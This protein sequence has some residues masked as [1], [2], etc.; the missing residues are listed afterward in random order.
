MAVLAGLRDKR[1]GSDGR[2]GKGVFGCILVFSVRFAVLG[3]EY[4]GVTGQVTIREH[5]NWREDVKGRTPHQKLQ[6][7]SKFPKS[8][9]SG[10]KSVKTEKVTKWAK[11]NHGKK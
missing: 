10:E 9:S 7:T 4:Y 8:L 2:G 5:R 1:G 6:K 3:V 11:I